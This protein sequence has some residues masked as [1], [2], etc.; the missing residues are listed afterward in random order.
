[1]KETDPNKRPKTLIT[2]K[3]QQSKKGKIERQAKRRPSRTL[4]GLDQRPFKSQLRNKM[5]KIKKNNKNM[6]N[7][8]RENIRGKNLGV[9]HENEPKQKK[10]GPNKQVAFVH[11]LQRMDYT[12]IS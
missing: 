2:F 9:T 7:K 6:L 5:V 8:K 10:K 3:G 11:A 1:V 4:V 12:K